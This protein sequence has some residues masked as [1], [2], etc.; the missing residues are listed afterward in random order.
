LGKEEVI[1]DHETR[2]LDVV[3]G[4]NDILLTYMSLRKIESHVKQTTHHIFPGSFVLYILSGVFGGR[5]GGG[6]RWRGRGS[7]DVLLLGVY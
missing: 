6:Y 1:E 4:W 5:V 3:D 2:V 7:F